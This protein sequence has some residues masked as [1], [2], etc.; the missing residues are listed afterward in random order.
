[1]RKSIIFLFALFAS[2]AISTASDSIDDT[3]LQKVDLDKSK[4]SDK[5]V[6]S[7]RSVSYLEAFYSLDAGIVEVYHDALGECEI[8]L[9]DSSGYVV[10]QSDFVSQSYSV[11]SLVLPDESDVYTLII[12]SEALYAYGY[13]VVE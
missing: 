10:V 8:L 5:V 11:E 1:M 4:D 9:L 7:P 6:D 3:S 13:I 12:D 2:I